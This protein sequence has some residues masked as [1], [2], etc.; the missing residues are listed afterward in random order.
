MTLTRIWQWLKRYWWV[1]AAAI[2]AV[3]LAIFLPHQAG[4]IFDLIRGARQSGQKEVAAVEEAH[5]V[6]IEKREASQRRYLET[7]EHLEHNYSVDL[8]D[9]AS[10]KQKRIKEITEQYNGRP[11]DLARKIAEEFD[12]QYISPE[13]I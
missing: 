9:L 2:V 4:R 8:Q 3:I 13:D 7:V 1:P 5:Q 10:D 12:L 6:E 11:E